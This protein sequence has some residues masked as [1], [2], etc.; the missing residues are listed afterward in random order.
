[1]EGE[2][3]HSQVFVVNA[4]S[5]GKEPFQRPLHPHTPPSAISIKVVLV[6]VRMPVLDKRSARE[7]L[8]VIPSTMLLLLARH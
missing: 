7:V 4:G 2:D 6:W 5:R 8:R 3:K 1:M